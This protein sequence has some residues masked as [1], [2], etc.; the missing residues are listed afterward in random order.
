MEGFQEDVLDPNEKLGA[1]KELHGMTQGG[2][3]IASVDGVALAP[4]A[5]VL[6]VWVVR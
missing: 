2:V 6:G 3:L 1:L 5:A 4:G